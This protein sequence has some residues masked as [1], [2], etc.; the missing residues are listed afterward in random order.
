MKSQRQELILSIISSGTIETQSQL[1][2]ALE[3]MGVFAT[4]AT[5]S[6]DI[7]SLQL[8]KRLNENGRNVYSAEKSD[9]KQQGPPLEKLLK[10]SKECVKSYDIAQ[11]I[12][13]MKTIP[14]LASAACSALDSL[15]FEHLVGTIA[16]DDTALLI[17]KN[18]DYA[19][20]FLKEINSIL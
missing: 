2:E 5:L 3:S 14:G 6:R 11:N 12:I 8:T 15:S 9:R 1:Q 7:K 16:G 17:F 18:N 13:V 10:I 19:A 4:Q 20:N